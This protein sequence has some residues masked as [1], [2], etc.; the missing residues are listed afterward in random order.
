LRAWPNK[1]SEI[2]F[3]ENLYK[4][5]VLFI[6]FHLPPTLGM[7]FERKLIVRVLSYLG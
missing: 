6:L 7:A 5:L 1:N 4:L 2:Y 3:N